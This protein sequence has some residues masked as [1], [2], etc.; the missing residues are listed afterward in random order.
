MI[1]TAF[2]AI[3][4]VLLF[5]GCAEKAS[6]EP[7][8]HV[9]AVSKKTRSALAMVDMP[10]T[11]GIEQEENRTVDVVVVHSANAEFGE[12]YNP[13]GV[14]D[15]FKKYNVTPHYMIGRNGT[16]YKLADENVLAH[17]AGVSKMADGRESVNHFSIGIE[18]I[19]SKIDYPTHAQYVAL[20]NL[21]KDIKT[22]HKIKYIVGHKDIAPTRKTDPWNFDF[23]V[24]RA[25]IDSDKHAKDTNR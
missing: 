2:W 20:A 3:L 9:N 8:K 18:L 16:I 17:H 11:F 4:S 21:I 14:Y 22:R 19:N 13:Q 23:V 12:P 24:L 15:T 1:R 6:V 7:A 25:M 5:A 10:A